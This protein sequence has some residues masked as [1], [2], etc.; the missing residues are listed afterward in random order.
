MAEEKKKSIFDKLVDAVT[1][2]DEKAAAA[3]KA[4]ADKAAA[5]KAAA[6]KAAADKAAADKAEA[7]RMAVQKAA[8]QKLAEEKIAADK[9]EADRMAVQR[10]A[11]QQLASDRIAADKAASVRAAAEAEAAKHKFIA[12]YKLTPDDTLS[13]VA[14]KYYGKATPEYWTLIYEANKDVI[15]ANPNIVRPGTVLKIPEL[16]EE[17]KTQK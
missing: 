7:D 10:A 12:E 15:G 13:H 2:R 6:E 8:I 14:L 5:E 11:I 17:L 16:P 1:D 4:A 9:A 3:E